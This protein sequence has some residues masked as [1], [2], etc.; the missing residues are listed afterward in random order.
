MKLLPKVPSRLVVA[1]ALT[2]AL[3]ALP[4]AASAAPAGAP[5]SAHAGQA[6]T[7]RSAAA[8]SRAAEVQ[9][10]ILAREDPSAQTGPGAAFRAPPP[11]NPGE[12]C[13]TNAT[14]VVFRKET[15][16]EVLYTVESG[17]AMR[18]EAYAGPEQYYGHAA[19]KANGYFYRYLIDQ[20]SCHK[21]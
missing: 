8:G 11:A 3:S 14:T 1:G 13:N 6:A 7:A 12:V 9:A 16:T 17:T 4:G 10:Q 18:I 5:V 20:S 2:T 15:G 19:G 21:T